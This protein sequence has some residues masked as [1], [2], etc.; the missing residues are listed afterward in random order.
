MYF[1][2]L[3]TFKKEFVSQI[4]GYKFQKLALG[5]APAPIPQAK[6]DQ[7]VEKDKTQ[8]KDKSFSN[9]VLQALST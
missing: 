1:L 8:K 6:P 7:Q 9:I 5:M 4:L 2:L 3:K